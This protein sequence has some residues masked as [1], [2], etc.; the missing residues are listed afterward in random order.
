MFDDVTIGEFRL[1][2][3]DEHR[4]Q[5]AQHQ[6]LVNLCQ[7]DQEQDQILEGQTLNYQNAATSLLP[8]RRSWREF[9]FRNFEVQNFLIIKSFPDNTL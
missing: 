5:Y 2:R 3:M 7:S 6:E 8:A 1:M 9:F 4:V